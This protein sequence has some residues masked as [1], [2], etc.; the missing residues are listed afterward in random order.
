[1]SNGVSPDWM[2]SR[3]IA[4]GQ[5]PISALVDITNYVM[6][7]FGRPAHAYDL[8]KLDGAVGARRARAGEQ[9]LALNEKTYALDGTMTVIA[10]DSGVHDIAG[11]MGGEHSGCSEATTDVL[12]EVAYFDPDRIGATGRA[13]NVASDARTR[14][15][16]GVDPDFLDDG[17]AILTDLILRICG[18]TASDVVRAGSP[19]SKPKIVAY[20][21]ALC[22]RLG[23]VDIAERTATHLYHPAQRT[24]RKGPD[25]PTPLAWGAAGVVA[26][27]L[28]VTG[29]AW[30]SDPPENRK[31]TFTDRTITLA[32]EAIPPAPAVAAAGPALPRWSDQ[33]LR[34]TGGPGLP[35]TNE[36]RF[37]Q[38]KFGRLGTLLPVPTARPDE[39]ERLL[40]I[41]IDGPIWTFLNRP[42]APPPERT[43][44]LPARF[45]R[46]TPAT[47][48]RSIS[49]ALTT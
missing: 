13:L 39:P 21:P 23:G 6:L 12:L 43:L 44:D 16:R 8:A 10:D 2:Q 42:D 28:V 48:A 45:Q 49:R 26:D 18:G 9:V 31:Y 1:M 27:R 22:R 7:A 34:G 46:P 15:E 32:A 40:L 25:L 35:F 4:A 30:L 47:L 19:P 17:L 41:E 24:W 3:L 29:G 5:R 20:D 11:I 36:R 38:F 37:S 14:F 33:A